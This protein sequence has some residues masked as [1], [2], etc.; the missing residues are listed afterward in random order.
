MIAGL[1]YQPH[2]IAVNETWDKPHTTGQHM[3]LNGYVYISNPRV[4]SRGGG[5]GMYIKQ[6][7]IFTPYAELSIMQEKLFE[8]LFV[9]IHFEGKRLIC[10]T[11][12]RA[13]RNDNL[14]L[15]GF[16]D[17]IEL[18]LGELNKTKSK[19]FLMEDLNLNLLDLSD[20]KTNNS[21]ISCLITTSTP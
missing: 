13:P 2:I 14:G 3:N 19:C 1:D 17:S 7:L 16:F 6:S 20:K 5:V 15:N 11:V 8:S 9:T 10:G 21:Q 4:A 12:Y 18:V